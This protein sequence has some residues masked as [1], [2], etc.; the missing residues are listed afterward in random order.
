MDELTKAMNEGRK[1]ERADIL[2]FIRVHTMDAAVGT[3]YQKAALLVLRALAADI[4]D[5]NHHKVVG[6]TQ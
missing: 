5:C 2:W 3:E 6:D 4:E 1:K